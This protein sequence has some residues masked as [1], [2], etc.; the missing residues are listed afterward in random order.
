MQ[1]LRVV[2][3]RRMHKLVATEALNIDNSSTSNNTNGPNMDKITLTE[4]ASRIR[5]KD[6][7]RN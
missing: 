3:M 4:A 5:Q 1:L 7:Q 6:S 2:T